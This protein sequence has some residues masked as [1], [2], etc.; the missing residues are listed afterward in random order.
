MGPDPKPRCDPALTMQL[1]AMVKRDGAGSL[2]NMVKP[3]KVQ[4]PYAP[5]SSFGQ[6]R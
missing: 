4:T 3:H 6:G 2:E 1:F 5:V